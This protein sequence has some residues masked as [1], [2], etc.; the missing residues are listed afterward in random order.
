MK[1]LILI[2]LVH[3]LILFLGWLA[4]GKIFTVVTLKIDPMDLFW[5]FYTIRACA[6]AL[7]LF[8][9]L[10]SGIPYLNYLLNRS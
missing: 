2:L 7:Y 3:L 4:L 6:E 8:L 1:K 9:A 10:A 5:R